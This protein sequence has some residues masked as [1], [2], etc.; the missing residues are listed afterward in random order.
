MTKYTSD[1]NKIIMNSRN[2]N[3]V[4][5]QLVEGRKA[6]SPQFSLTR[7]SQLTGIPSRG[8][9]S[10]V[11][12]NQKKLGRKYLQ[13][14]AKAFQM[15]DF[16]TMVFD[17]MLQRDNAR[18]AATAEKLEHTLNAAKKG[19]DIQ[20]ISVSHAETPS[21][22]SY[23][24]Y[25]AFSLFS[26]RP[27]RENL[28]HYFGRNRNAELREA[29][30]DLER[31]NLIARNDDGSFESKARQVFV[32][33]QSSKYAEVRFIKESLRFAERHVAAWYPKRDEAFMHSMFV[34]VNQKHYQ[35]S[36]NAL[37]NFV[38]QWQANVQSEQA[39]SLISVN[40]QVFPSKSP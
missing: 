29:L 16:Q 19:L 22:F 27:T 31:L 11:L 3:E 12:R 28:Q 24:V 20:T 25:C 23:Q 9:L 7:L 26:N 14:I 4:I 21:F 38:K 40:L 32:K 18:T 5:Q 30:D 6:T 10:E 15:D 36:L 8:Y 39:D 1:I 33:D 34:S 37:R 13:G 35:E 2:S 17:L